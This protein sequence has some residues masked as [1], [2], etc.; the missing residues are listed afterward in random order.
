MAN[1]FTRGI[2]T[3]AFEPRGAITDSLPATPVISGAADEA[4]ANAGLNLATAISRF[5]DQAAA[6]EGATEGKISGADPAFRPTNSVTIRG[7]HYDAAA[8]PIY[9]DNLEA[10]FR[11]DLA[12]VYEANKGSAPALFNAMKVLKA[13]YDRQ[14]VFPEI[15]GAFNAQFTRLATAYA[16]QQRAAGN[17]KAKE[18]AQAALIN[19]V[20]QVTTT[21]ARLILAD[22]TNPAT[23]EAV[24]AEIKKLEELYGA[25]AAQNIISKPQAAKLI[26]DQRASLT[27]RA[28][29]AQAE[30]MTT[31]GEIDAFRAR[32]K[33]LFIDGKIPTLDADGY[34]SLDNKLLGLQ[35]SRVTA[36]TQVENQLKTKINDYVERTVN[37]HA[38]SP[39]EWFALSSIG[40]VSE[41]G[42]LIVALGEQKLKIAQGLRAMPI[43][44]VDA[45]VA[46]MRRKLNERGGVNTNEADLVAFAEKYAKDQRTALRTNALGLAE[47]KGIVKQVAPLS[48]E[49]FLTAADPRAAAVNLGNELKTR[50]AQADA[51]ANTFSIA[52]Q[53]FQPAELERVKEIV[54][55]GGD[56]AL[57]LAQSIVAAGGDKAPN[58]FA[59]LGHDAPLLAQAGTILA[60]GGSLPA[61]RDALEWAR[62]KKIKDLPNPAGTWTQALR[63]EYGRAFLFHAEDQSRARVAAQ[64]I[65][66]VRLDRDKLDPK[67]KESDAIYRRALQEAA[68]AIYVSGDRYGGVDPY[69]APAWWTGSAQVLLPASVKAGNFR[70]VIDALRIEDLASLPVP[71]LSASGANYTIRDFRAATPVAVRTP[72]GIGYRFA[73][74]DPTSDDPKWIRG[75]DGKSFVLP[76]A[77]VEETLRRRVP[78]SFLQAR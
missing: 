63:E 4:V 8:I 73:L 74:G 69:K 46:E 18:D 38:T 66:E 62:I 25:A 37:G 21:A 39:D 14:H 50:V 23:S 11:A 72:S 47:R 70:S 54:N 53:Y 26:I 52:P 16:N 13:E 3:R 40:N 42:R 59:Q 36:T 15:Q 5:A 30:T 71:P 61:A 9:V 41:Q 45:A 58:I 24:A 77:A 6:V 33:Q 76:F 2:E 7:R 17:A 31:A 55:Q 19:N 12:K 64:A 67:S 10:N 34:A 68:G 32:T 20:N 43:D 48:L 22:P 35:K 60:N 1:K 51:V 65:A 29:E 28:L 49:S 56:R 78:G 57:A 27:M 75:A 44:Q